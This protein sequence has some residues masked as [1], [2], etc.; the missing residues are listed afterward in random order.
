MMT[1]IC[2][3]FPATGLV[4]VPIGESFG[5]SCQY[6]AFSKAVILKIQTAQQTVQ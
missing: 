2:M 5:E 4:A 1:C 6:P 3:N